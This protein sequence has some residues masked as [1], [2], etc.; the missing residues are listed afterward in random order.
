DYPDRFRFFAHLPT[1]TD[2]DAALDELTYALDEL[3]ADGV[4]LT[5]VYGT[6]AE[7]RS[8]GDDIFEPLWAELDRR[9]ALVFLHGEQTPG[10]NRMR[11]ALLPIPVSEVPNET[12][13]G[14]ADLVTSGRKRQ[15]PNVRIILS[16]SGGSTPFLAARVAVLSSYLGCELTPEEIIAD[17]RTFYFETALSGFETNLVALENFVPPEQILFGTDFPAVSPQMA[18]WYTANVDAYFADRPHVLA[19]VM[20]GNANILLSRPSVTPALSR[21][22]HQR[23]GSR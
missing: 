17:F 9:R 22:S 10:R 20:H 3:D 19:Q 7:A 12:Y 4:A 8:L 11:N 18:G 5:N 23:E 16:H 21:H 6:G 13:K 14:A 1:P 2:V 15:Y